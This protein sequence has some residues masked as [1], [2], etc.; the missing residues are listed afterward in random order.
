MYKNII[1]LFLLILILTACGKKGEPV[2]K[3]ESYNK[4]KIITY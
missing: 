4:V 3:T 1:L 2:Y